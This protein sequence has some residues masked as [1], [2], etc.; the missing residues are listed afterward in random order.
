MNNFINLFNM[1]AQFRTNPLSIITQRFNVP[2][3][4]TSPGDVVQHL[5][6]S[7]QVTQDQVDAA[8][9]MKDNP[10]FQNMFR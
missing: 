6:D 10:M 9:K 5:L 2:R 4:I 7:K 3:N 8:V 1:V